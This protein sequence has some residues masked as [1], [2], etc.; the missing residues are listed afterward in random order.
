[1]PIIKTKNG[2]KFGS[3]GKVYKK[4]PD[5]LKQMRAIKAN[6]NKKRK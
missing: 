4:R 2:Y 1:M 5:A 3:K 6:Q